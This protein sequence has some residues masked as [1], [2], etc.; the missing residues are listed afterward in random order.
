MR[1]KK[2][3]WS[4]PP[5]ESWLTES[6]VTGLWTG[7][8]VGD[9]R[10]AMSV[11]K[12]IPARHR[13]IDGSGGYNQ[14]PNAEHDAAVNEFQRRHYRWILR[15]VSSIEVPS[16]RAKGLKETDAEVDLISR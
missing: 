8:D 2:A 7:T 1:C 10:M 15:T 16:E 4:G 11:H 5:D 13:N 9:Q 14:P 12:V 3:S 6:D